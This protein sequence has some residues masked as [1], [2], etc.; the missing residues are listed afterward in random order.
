MGQTGEQKQYGLFYEQLKPELEK[1]VNQL[2]IGDGIIIE[3]KASH[4]LVDKTIGYVYSI[5]S[6]SLGLTKGRT[7]KF[8]WEKLSNWWESLSR[9]YYY[10]FENISVVDPVKT[11]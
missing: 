10:S 2:S 7:P 11:A 5:R 6:D 8:S 9:H 3:H 1:V 4:C